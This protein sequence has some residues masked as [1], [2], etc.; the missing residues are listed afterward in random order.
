MP[1]AD[2]QEPRI[3]ELELLV[4]HLQ[5]DLETLNQVLLDQRK[6]LEELR[7]VVTRVDDRLARLGQT[8]EPYDP[9]QERPPHY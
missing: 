6:E 3:V 8:D 7:N 5:R 4:T 9:A 1:P 2:S